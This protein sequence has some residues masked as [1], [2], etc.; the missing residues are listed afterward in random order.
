MIDIIHGC[1]NFVLLTLAKQWKTYIF[2]LKTGSASPDFMK[3]CS[4]AMGW[5][6]VSCKVSCSYVVWG[7]GMAQRDY[8]KGDCIYSF[9][10][11]VQIP[12]F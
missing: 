5:E 9:V 6:K 10:E 11:V 3:L 12:N 1:S 2:C 8:S 4:W 7:Y